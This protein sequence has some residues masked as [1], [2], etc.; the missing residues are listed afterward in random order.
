MFGACR[1]D[2]DTVLQLRTCTIEGNTLRIPSQLA[3]RDYDKLNAVI[4]GLG[5]KW[6]RKRAC[7][8]FAR[9]VE[10]VIAD[11]CLTGNYVDEKKSRELFETPEDLAEL[12]VREA[13]L[14]S[15]AK[16]LEPS[17][18]RGR[19][20]ALVPED[21]ALTAVEI[22]PDDAAALAIAH[23]SATVLCRDFLSIAPEPIYDAVIMNPPFVGSRTDGNTG[24]DV[25]HV[26]HAYKFLKPGGR[27]IAIVSNGAL[28][29]DRKRKSAFQSWLASVDAEVEEL[30]PDTFAESGTRTVTALVCIT[31]Q[32]SRAIL[33][34]AKILEDEFGIEP[35]R[36]MSASI[37]LAVLGRNLREIYTND[38]NGY[39]DEDT[40]QE[41][42][43][44]RERDEINCAHYEGE[45][46]TL[47]RELGVTTFELNSD[48]RGR[49]I[50]IQ[51]PSRRA[52]DLSDLWAIDEASPSM[53]GMLGGAVVAPVTIATPDPTAAALDEQLAL[54]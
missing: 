20:T 41:D 26:S 13:E 7:H 37:R 8:V 40:D 48:P 11:A 36:A 2:S 27:L 23:P 17:A 1:I 35:Q 22:D 32:P 39:H 14:P 30:G 15:Y 19:I 33:T 5:G 24:G 31:R 29:S 51:L 50:K 21:C 47:L 45:V 38:S 54:F 28:M 42:T 43:A 46:K 52:N 4:K 6:M 3:R 44:A 16:V 49:A 9:N 12:M 10:D 34:F 53:P 18:G 25:E